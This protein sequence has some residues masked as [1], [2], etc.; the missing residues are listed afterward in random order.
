MA[1]AKVLADR[2]CI[3]SDVLTDETI[4]RVGILSPSTLKLVDEKDETNI[5]FE[6]ASD[7]VNGFSKYGAVFKEG[8]SLG[9]IDEDLMELS[10]EEREDKVK[11]IL[12]VVLTRLNK[13]EEQVNEYLENVPDISDDVEFM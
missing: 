9:V 10:I 8:K 11:T 13:I 3:T 7:K 6:V 2:I 12:T 5:L 4:E 1:K